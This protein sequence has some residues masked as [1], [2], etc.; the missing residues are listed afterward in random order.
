MSRTDKDAPYWVNATWRP[1]H[2]Q[3]CQHG[4]ARC[5]LAPRCHGP[6]RQH[7]DWRLYAWTCRWEPVDPRHAISGPPRWF[8]NHVWEAP[9]RQAARRAC[10]QAAAEHRADGRVEVDPPVWQHRHGAWWLWS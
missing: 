8:I 5:T 3:A 4:R 9:Q 7:P 2:S 1:E 10:R 6:R